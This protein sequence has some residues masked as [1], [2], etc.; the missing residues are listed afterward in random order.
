L[1]EVENRKFSIGES[2]LFIVNSREI[3]A[4]NSGIK[5]IEMLENT[6]TKEL[7][8]YELLGALAQ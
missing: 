3:S 4:I 7:E 2:T 6:A 8:L 1:L 5:W